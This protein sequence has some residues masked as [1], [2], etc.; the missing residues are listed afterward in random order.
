MLNAWSSDRSG[1]A[2]RP[3]LSVWEVDAL[4]R[5]RK[6][7]LYLG[8]CLGER[9][10]FSRPT[11]TVR[12]SPESEHISVGGYGCGTGLAALLGL[13]KVTAG[14]RSAWGPLACL[15]RSGGESCCAAAL[16][17]CR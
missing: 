16:V 11:A 1:S 2:T 9:T 8:L 4:C 7:D 6:R 3:A 12:P 15:R 5:W 13:G 14:L 17:R 10:T